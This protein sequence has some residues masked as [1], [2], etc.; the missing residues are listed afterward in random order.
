MAFVTGLS[1]ILLAFFSK[2]M[3]RRPIGYLPLA[4]PPFIGMIFEYVYSKHKNSRFSTPWYWIV[5][6]IISTA[7]VITFS[8]N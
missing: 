7:L 5:A 3:F 8:W 1:I 2:R 4:I 6:I